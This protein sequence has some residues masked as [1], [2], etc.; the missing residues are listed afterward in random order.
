VHWCLEDFA[1]EAD[2]KASE[3]SNVRLAHSN[4]NRRCKLTPKIL[5]K[6]ND[7][8]FSNSSLILSK[9]NICL[10]GCPYHF[11]LYQCVR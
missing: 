5:R 7:F 8:F 2:S 11:I 9:K 3:E 4:S 6:K 10:I 1:E